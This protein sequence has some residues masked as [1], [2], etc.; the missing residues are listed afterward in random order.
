MWINQIVP[1]PEAVDG[2]IQ[3]IRKCL[4]ANRTLI[5]LQELHKSVE[6][7]SEIRKQVSKD[8]PEKLKMAS[9]ELRRVVT[10]LVSFYIAA[11]T[12]IKLLKAQL[13]SQESMSIESS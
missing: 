13:T 6:A 9:K 12:E 4:D 1:T 11:S 3:A 2:A 8:Y 10:I 7:Q 5:E